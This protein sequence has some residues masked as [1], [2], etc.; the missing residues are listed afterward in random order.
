M[1]VNLISAV[2]QLL[3]PEVI[4]KIASFLG[5]DQSTAQK[6]AVA[7]IPTILASL[8]DLVGTP[9]GANQL[10]KLLS[11]QQGSNPI[12]L[13]HSSGAPG[14]AQMGSSM[15]SGL[16][17]G[18]TMD[19][20]GQ[21][22]GNFAGTGD[23]GGKS[24]LA[25]VG[26]LVLGML[27]RQQRD[28]GV[29]ANGLASLLRSQKDQ[30]MAAIPSGLGDQLSALG[31]IDQT[32]SGMATAAATGSRIAGASGATAASQAAIA[33]GRTQWPYWLV[34]LAILGGFAFLYALQRPTEQTVAQSTTAT[35][36]STATVG[37]APADLTVDGVNLANQ[38]NSSLGTLKAQLPTITDE[39]S[40]QAAMPK[41]NDAISQL[42]G[43]TARAAK[44]SP[45][46]RRALAKLIVAAAPAIN[47]MCDKVS[48]TPAGT[49][50]KPVI[51]NLRAKLDELAKV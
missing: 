51:D 28:A 29:D 36:P 43:I 45:E 4:A 46:A 25:V 21:A 38:V 10:S 2:Q 17:G 7:A 34:A 19:T 33:A 8:S 41:I 14:L 26:P 12:D 1:A 15:L 6:A 5:M 22:I 11:Q 9:A 16:L 35:R 20:M 24:L 13:L 3:T 27:G 37:M 44:L 48:A 47:E 50:A 23:A 42:D 31:L 40:A 39:A 18:R 49:I 32:R 30:F